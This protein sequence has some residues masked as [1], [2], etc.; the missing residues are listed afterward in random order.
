VLYN[1]I[2]NIE[3]N[4]LYEGV[5]KE[6][7]EIQENHAVLQ[8]LFGCSIIHEYNKPERRKIPKMKEGKT[9]PEWQE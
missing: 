3:T 4:E 9:N 1:S 2:I 7:N 6:V 8:P 5:E